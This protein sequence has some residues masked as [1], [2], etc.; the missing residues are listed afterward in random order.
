MPKKNKAECLKIENGEREENFPDKIEI[1]DTSNES[2]T[3]MQKLNSI[4]NET[5][6]LQ[7]E[8]KLKENKLQESYS[9]L[10][11]LENKSNSNLKIQSMNL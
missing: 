11:L 7:E 2:H 10:S 3:S 9:E 5:K 1:E 6:I 4:D 8:L